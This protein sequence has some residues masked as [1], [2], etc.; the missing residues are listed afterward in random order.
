MGPARVGGWELPEPDTLLLVSLCQEGLGVSV[1]G[2]VWGSLYSGWGGEELG[3]P[4]ASA[5]PGT[6]LGTPVPGVFGHPCAGDRFGGPVPGLGLGSLC[7]FLGTVPLGCGSQVVWAP[8]AL[9]H[10]WAPVPQR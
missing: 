6:D 9:Q 3:D 4:Y 7:L 10:H 1:P 5:V 2:R 8:Q